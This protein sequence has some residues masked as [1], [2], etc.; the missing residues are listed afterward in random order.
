MALTAPGEECVEDRDAP[1]RPLVPPREPLPDPLN[2]VLE[3][4]WAAEAVLGLVEDAAD[5]AA[6][7]AKLG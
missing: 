7:L 3:V 5:Y 1:L 4:H 6:A 2:Q